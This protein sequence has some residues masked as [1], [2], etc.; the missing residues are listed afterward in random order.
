[1]RTAAL[2]IFAFFLLWMLS[3]PASAQMAAAPPSGEIDEETVLGFI[4]IIAAALGY[5]WWKRNRRGDT[6]SGVARQQPVVS[7]RAQEPPVRDTGQESQSSSA[8]DASGATGSVF[9][10][11]RRGDAGDVVG[12]ISDRLVDR[13][14]KPHVFKDVD[15]IP[16]GVDFRKHLS[17]SVGKCRVFLAIIS[18]GW[19]QQADG[20]RRLDQ[21]NDFVRIEMEAALQRNIPV[22]PVLVQGAALPNE[23]E[24][25]ASLRELAYRNATVVR[26]DPDF[27]ADIA[28]LMD[29]IAFHLKADT[30]PAH[31]ARPH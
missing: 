20:E 12:R 30:D 28:R 9:I 4:V 17:D 26:A 10:S 8:R 6:Q 21:P 19:V 16:L 11:Y 5:W 23:Q 29:G 3:E 14:G 24:L 7:A 25:P 13:F 15:S 1:M 27:N 18:R 31:P 22:I 2:P